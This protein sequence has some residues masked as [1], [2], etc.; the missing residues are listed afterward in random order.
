M[1]PSQIHPRAPPI[2]LGRSAGLRA[3]PGLGPRGLSTPPSGLVGSSAAL[4][5]SCSVDS[6]DAVFVMG[7]APALS[8]SILVEPESLLS[9][10]DMVRPMAT[11]ITAI[12]EA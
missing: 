7:Q 8:D 11:R 6:V 10:S 3:L 4:G 5:A 12:T 9:S 2:T 1:I